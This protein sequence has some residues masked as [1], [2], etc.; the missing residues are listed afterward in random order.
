[1]EHPL[2]VLILEILVIL[3]VAV[4]SVVFF[5][6]SIFCFIVMLSCSNF[7]MLSSRVLICSSMVD[8]W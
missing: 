3:D 7:I 2:L 8:W 6:V 4:D 5:I 1:M